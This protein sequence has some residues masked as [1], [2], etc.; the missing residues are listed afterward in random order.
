M[1]TIVETLA[2]AEQYFHA[3][4][5]APVEQLCR[6][7]LQV[8]PCSG[9]ALRLLSLLAQQVNGHGLVLAEQGR[10]TEA[11][12]Y[13]EEALRLWPDYPEV[14]ANLGD[15]LKDMGRFADA[16]TRYRE[17]M[18][19]LPSL[20]NAH[21][22]LGVLLNEQRRFS[23]ALACYDRALHLKPDFAEIHNNRGNTL[24][25]LGRFGEAEASYRQAVR[26][27][28]DVAEFHNNLGLAL[29]AQSKQDE[30]RACFEEAVRL[31]PTFAHGLTCLGFCYWEAGR[32]EESLACYRK[33]IALRP[34]QYFILSN[35][36]YTLHFSPHYDP[37]A[38]FA[39]HRCAAKQLEPVPAQ[40]HPRG[41]VSRDPERRLRIGY[42]SGDFR[43]HV[44]G[45]Y[46][47][48]VIA[49]HDRSQFEVFCY[50]TVR[51]E[52]AR[53]RRIMALADHWHSLA[54]LSDA[55]AASCIVSD[56]IDL[57]IDLAGHTA[58]NRLGVFARK[59]AR[60]QISH[61]GYPDTTGLTAMDY[62]LSDPYCDPPG[63][64]ERFHSEKV[65][66]LPEAHWC[67]APTST[68]EVTPLP[69]QEPGV[70]TFASFNIEAKVTESMMVLWARILSDLPQS[71]LLVLTRSPHAQ[72][73]R[74]QG[75]FARQGINM[76]RVKLVPRTK[77]E[78]YYKLYQQVDICLD[79]Y[80]YTG[81][82]TTADALWMGVPVVTLAGPTCVT[83]LGVSALV[84][85]GLQ[86]L[87]TETQTA[88]VDAAVHLARDLPRLRELRRHLR[89]RVKRT[90]SDVERFARQLE[91]AYRSMWKSH[92]EGR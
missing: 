79:T 62:R 65:V 31:K 64:T 9:E 66:R 25:D 11:A 36:L 71:R 74:I 32:V 80:P 28:S 85:A 10:P 49:T 20:L 15:V 51:E 90:L 89:G 91:A 60:I 29:S 50:P 2:L 69:A 44:V 16:E 81:N 22:N 21:N 40:Y 8:D 35:L 77:P 72:D 92:S 86:D 56:Q 38:V 34:D 14:H 18:R 4:Q 82:N 45:R 58:R 5:W 17:A 53:T 43:E 30:A 33:A 13:F 78:D 26:L 76:E 84:L 19:L 12:A 59:P 23:E 70:V 42:V 39:E 67:Y 61:Y 52:D 48:A 1:A 46:S 3:G 7:V 73:D 6:Q 27:R 24:K 87:V 55:E 54:G 47:E 83:R 37:E 57:L 88:Y 63:L 41:A 68:P 75:T